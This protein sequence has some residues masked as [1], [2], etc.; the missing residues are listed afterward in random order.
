M[1]YGYFAEASM[2]V[3]K[4]NS[5]GSYAWSKVI[6]DRKYADY[7]V[8]YIVPKGIKVNSNGIYIIGDLHCSGAASCDL[9]FDYSEGVDN[10]TGPVTFITK[11]NLDGTYGWTKSNLTTSNT[12]H[13]PIDLDIDSNGNVF[14][15]GMFKDTA[16]F[17]WSGTDNHTSVGNYDMYITKLNSSGTY[18]WTKTFGNT[19]FDTASSISIDPTDGNIYVTGYFTGSVNFN[20]SGSAWKNGGATG[21]IFV[22]KMDSTG[23]YTWTKSIPTNST[24]RAA[25]YLGTYTP[26]VGEVVNIS[27]N[28]YIVHRTSL[29]ISDDSNDKEYLYVRVIKLDENR[30][31]D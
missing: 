9:D 21:S 31:E 11:I 16:N 22:M 29:A 30:Y 23:N 27:G 24:S 8:T 20:P 19:N 3:T 10:K 15:A 28:P 13:V 14:I 25:E 26:K 2:A 12:Y 5:D 6:S 17:D 7:D 4:I 18:Q 1:W